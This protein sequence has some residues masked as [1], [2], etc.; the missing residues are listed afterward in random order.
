VERLKQSDDLKE[1]S[2]RAKEKL[3]IVSISVVVLVA[4]LLGG[5][6]DSML[7]MLIV[8][9]GLVIYADTKRFIR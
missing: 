9:A 3:N 1:R 8:G 6:F 4:V 7:I 5:A 2:L